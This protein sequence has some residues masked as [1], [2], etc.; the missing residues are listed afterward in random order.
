V[1]Q[2]QAVRLQ[3]GVTLGGTGLQLVG[4][5]RVYACGITPYDVTHLGH[6]ATYV[7]IDV[8][9]RVLAAA[10][11]Q[12]TVCRNVTNVDDVLTAAASRA[13]SPY[14]E[15]AA[16]QQFY[17]DG[18]MTALGV[19]RPDLEPRAHAHVQQVIELASG[20]LQ[21]G[22]AYQR[23]GQVYFRGTGM[24]ARAGLDH[25]TALRLSREYGDHPGDVARDDPFDAPVWQSSHGDEPAWDSPWGPGRPGWHAE[26][27]AMALDAFGP[28]VDVQ[29]GGADL[30][31]PHHA[32][33]AA[34]AEALTGVTPFA[35]ARLQAAV[36]T[37]GGAKMAKSAGNLV[38][39]K[40]L[41][42][43]YPMAAVRMLILDRRWA[44]DWDYRPRDLEHAAARVERL[45]AAAGRPSRGALGSDD[46]ARA[47]I[48]S[49]LAR[50][51]D[52]PTALE[53]AEDAGGPVASELADSLSLR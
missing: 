31:F 37:I 3:P 19:R 47:A 46:A 38:L 53:I 45:S 1:D 11:V 4:R 35:R 48:R 32:Y 22:A 40:D 5:A 33:Q 36:V 44:A 16:I 34:M 13:G 12:V 18:D 2:Q 8:L 6:A 9:A 29:A 23:D 30:R 20:L 43:S 17:F 50:D 41:L 28:A 27:T 24:P 39:V 52:V 21:R 14:D 51:L 25:D 15:F 26:C 7:W 49:A 42:A 10:G